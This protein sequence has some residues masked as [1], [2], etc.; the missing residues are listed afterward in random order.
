MKGMELE[1]SSPIRVGSLQSWCP[2]QEQCSRKVRKGTT[3]C[4]WK[5]LSQ[6]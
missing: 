4:C 3:M 5:E 1:M 6:W 2:F